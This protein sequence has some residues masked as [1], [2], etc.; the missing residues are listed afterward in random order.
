[1]GNST[2]LVQ[3]WNVDAGEELISLKAIPEKSCPSHFSLDGSPFA[4][5]SYDKTVHVWRA[6]AENLP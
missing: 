4:S 3:L 1:M 2:G 6:P 5:A